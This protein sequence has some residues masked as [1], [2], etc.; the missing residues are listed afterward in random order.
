MD[1]FNYRL[2]IQRPKQRCEDC[3]ATAYTDP[4][5]VFRCVVCDHEYFETCLDCGCLSGWCDCPPKEAPPAPKK[6]RRPARSK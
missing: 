5:E 2:L 6:K 1:D 3:G 4:T